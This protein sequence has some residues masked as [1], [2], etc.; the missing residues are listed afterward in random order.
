MFVAFG[1]AGFLD[2]GQTLTTIQENT[3]D[4]RTTIADRVRI[5]A[6]APREATVT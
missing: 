1:L 6:I 4:I 3:I 2:T 5:G